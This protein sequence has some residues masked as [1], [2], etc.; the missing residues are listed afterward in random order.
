MATAV[1]NVAPAAAEVVAEVQTNIPAAHTPEYQEWRTTGKIP[2]PK[3]ADPAPAKS[4][5]ATAEVS[6]DPESAPQEHKP[7]KETAAERAV[8]VRKEADELQAELDRRAELRKKLAE[9]DEP[10]KKAEPATAKDKQDVDEFGLKVPKKP[11]LDDFETFE[12]FE[13]AKDKYA[14]D[15]AEYK[16]ERAVRKDRKERADQ[17]S[18]KAL[19]DRLNEGRKRYKEAFDT[20]I[21]PVVGRLSAE[22]IAPVIQAV[23]MDSEI[24]PDLLY[25]LGS[26]PVEF[27]NFIELAQSNPSKALRKLILLEDLTQKELSKAAAPEKKTTDA[28]P[29]PKELNT[30][31]SQPADSEVN[32]VNANDQ[33]AFNEARNR[34]D[35]QRRKGL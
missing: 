23:V 7:K 26:D 22:K 31:G 2:Q 34:A 32:A 1:Q 20:K 30:R 24:L 29:P 27:D 8:K 12:A 33:R 5:Q 13:E 6:A 18:N 35:I 4:E 15:N 14:D 10:T 19:N 9:P 28:P 11:K 17:E 3:T 21:K 16:A 25:A